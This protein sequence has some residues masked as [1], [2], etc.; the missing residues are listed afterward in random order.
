MKNNHE[1]EREER[2]Q[3]ERKFSR[4]EREGRNVIIIVY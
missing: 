1:L 2:G 4:A 3:E